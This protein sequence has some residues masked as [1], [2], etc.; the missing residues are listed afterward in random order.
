MSV[1]GLLYAPTNFRK[2]KTLEKFVAFSFYLFDPTILL[3]ILCFLCSYLS[4]FS[5]AT[6]EKARSVTFSAYYL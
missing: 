3:I 2:R 4:N 5:F 6:D 1:F